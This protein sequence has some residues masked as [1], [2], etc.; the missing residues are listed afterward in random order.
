[1]TTAKQAAANRQN[2]K[3]STGPATDEGRERAKMNALKHGLTA[4]TAIVSAERAKDYE[5]FRDAMFEDRASVGAL[6][7]LLVERMVV[8]AWRLRRAVRKEADLDRTEREREED[9]V[10]Y[11]AR[12]RGTESPVALRHWARFK[13]M[14]WSMPKRLWIAR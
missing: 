10:E 7:C 14:I 4:K 13:R 5:V 12:S 1:M 8:C 11:I 3:Q 2:A 9:A 6:E